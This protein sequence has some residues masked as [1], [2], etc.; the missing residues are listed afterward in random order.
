[1]KM[2]NKNIS[3]YDLQTSGVIDKLKN[4]KT[5]DDVL[6]FVQRKSDCVAKYEVPDGKTCFVKDVYTKTGISSIASSRLYEKAGI[7]TPPVHLV[8]KKDS[9]TIQT[10]QPNVED[11]DGVK[12]ILANSDLEYKKI[13]TMAFGKYKWQIFYDE[14]LIATLLEFMTP[15]CL[16]SFQNMFLV[17]ELRTDGDK[18]LKNYFFYKT[19]DSDKYEG[20]IGIDLDLMQILNYCG[21]KKDDFTRFLF[22][23]YQTATPHQ[24]YDNTCY[25]ERIT[26]MCQLAQDGVLST[27]NID[28]IT[29][30]LD[31]DFPKEIK[32]ACKDSKLGFGER[33]DII[34]PVERLWEYNRETIGRELGM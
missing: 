30:A 16:T 20:V 23:P 5:I 32:S 27:S 31:C 4:G 6:K 17:D 26:D 33:N 2:T 22:C 7:L 3:F 13:Q 15:S 28:A 10:I 8:T 25:K 34:K 1:M 11:I 19:K 12:T 29:T 24:A 9:Y 18:H 21:S 14:D